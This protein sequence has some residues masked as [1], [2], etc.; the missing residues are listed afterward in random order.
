MNKVLWRTSLREILGS[1]TRF[2]SILGIVFLGV[3]F[4]VGLSATGPDMVQTADDY[5]QKQQ[6]ADAQIFTPL[7]MSEASLEDVRDMDQVAYAEGRYFQ[8]IFLADKDQT[9][10]LYSYD[11]DQKLNRVKVVK[12]RLPKNDQE[13]ALDEIAETNHSYQTGDNFVIDGHEDSFVNKELTVVGFVESPQYIENFSRGNTTVGKGM[14]DFFAIMSPKNFKQSVFSEVLVQYKNLKGVTAYSDTYKDRW[15]SNQEKTEDSLKDDGAKRLQELKE[16]NQKQIDEAKA[17]LEAGKTEAAQQTQQLSEAQKRLETGKKEYAASQ[18]EFEAK[19]QEAQAQI[20]ERENL[21]APQQQ[22]LTDQKEELGKLKNLAERKKQATEQTDAL[23]AQRDQAASEMNQLTTAKS[24]LEQIRDRAAQGTMEQLQSIAQQLD[25]QKFGDVLQAVQQQ[26][27]QQAQ[28]TANQH[29]TDINTEIQQLQPKVTQLEAQ[30]TENQQILAAELPTP[31]ELR[32]HQA[33][34]DELEQWLATG[35]QQLEAAKTE[36]AAS[37]KQG[38]E[39]LEQAKQQLD[40]AQKTY[41]EGQKALETAN[42]DTLA[43]AQKEIAEKEAALAQ[44][45]QLE[46]TVQG[47]NDN[48]GYKEYQDNA[49]RISSLATVFPLIFFLIAALVTLTTMTRMVEEK[50]GELGTFKALGY[51]NREISLKFILYAALAG[52]IGGLAGLSVGFYLLPTIIFN[53]YGQLYNLNQVVTPWY[54]S[55]AVAAMLVALLCSVGTALFV[56]RYDLKATPATL[57]QPRA[58]KKG[59]RIWLERVTP[60]WSRL[61]FIQKVTMRN[62]FRYK[63]R[64]LMTILG[65]AGCMSMLITGFGLRDSIGDIV[66]IQFDNILQYQGTVVFSDPLSQREKT[67]Y[68]QELDKLSSFKDHLGMSTEM[69]TAETGEVN[70][71]EISLHVPEDSKKL[72]SFISFNDRTSQKT[73]Q[74]TDQGVIINEKLAELFE[75]KPGD[76]LT[77]KA[78]DGEKY[79][80]KIAHIAENY[81]GH[82][83]YMTPKYYDQLFNRVPDY[84]TDLLLFDKQPS[85][86]QENTI[87]QQLMGRDK[88]I[89]VAFLS[90]S[91]NALK[92]T[93]ESLNVIM[94]VLIVSA[95]LLAFIVLYNLTNINIS[96]RIRELSTIKVLG[97]Y[98]KE[99]VAYVYRENVLLTLIGIFAGMFLGKIEHRYILKTVELDVT[100]FSPDIQPVSYLY[101]ALITLFFALIVGILMYFKL[102]K[103]NM[104][105]AL[106]A[107]E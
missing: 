46:Y 57:M 61:T 51:W 40:Q 75:L 90:E 45:D 54:L 69:F 66:P 103:I 86:S 97:F 100:M 96:E 9:I 18:Q 16:S 29:L 26:N 95:G 73:Y 3:A 99:V 89:S 30:W 64:M 68:Q 85:S 84:N 79:K 67:D 76:N 53:A 83:I 65:I 32:E 25:A 22:A 12:G 39:Q 63:Q 52:G 50:R 28:T 42:S 62:L 36:L 44:L 88:V 106:K 94:W 5:Y 20:D 49:D 104:I 74:L 91:R 34:I 77:I 72:D 35:T 13:I 23:K 27:A 15:E 56:L 7:G 48:P 98:N 107:N 41:D 60:L 19:S 80:V 1:K 55:Y 101:S 38:Q 78:T 102:K 4:F 6:L 87:G 70:Q 8:D 11:Q 17:Q 10:R 14:I 2:L 21:L 31:E 43:K 71:Q 82:F 33:Q 47:R 59:K 37:Q 81:V 92:D 105:E 24:Q 93:V 58:P